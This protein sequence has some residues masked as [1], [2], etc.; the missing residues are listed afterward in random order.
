MSPLTVV[1]GMLLDA[2]HDL[3]GMLAPPRVV[4]RIVLDAVADET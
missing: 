3:D 1:V 2:R 4:D